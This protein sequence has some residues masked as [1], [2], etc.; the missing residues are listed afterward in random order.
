MEARILLPIDPMPYKRLNPKYRGHD[1]SYRKWRKQASMVIGL[2]WRH[3]LFKSP[4]PLRVHSFFFLRKPAKGKPGSK[5]VWP[6][7]AFDLDN[8][9]KALYDA[10]TD[11]KKVWQDDA[12]VVSHTSQKLWAKPSENPRIEV[13]ISKLLGEGS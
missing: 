3:P 1:P 9:E 12:Q 13:F 11:T 5:L 10:I 7:H 6:T 2:Q 8:L 4:M